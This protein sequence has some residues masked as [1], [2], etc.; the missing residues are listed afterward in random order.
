M[1]TLSEP[2]IREHHFYVATAKSV[3]AHDKYGIVL[4]R[5]P[6]SLADAARYGL[7]PLLLYGIT[8]AGTPIRWSTYSLAS[9]PRSF[10]S[11]LQEA[12]QLA[13]GLRGR[14]DVLKVNRHIMA[15]STSL[16]QPH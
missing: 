15:A 14:P 6:M 4:V 2:M 5:D 11:V 12:W 7:K 9:E 8:A 1:P 16:S 10:C 13:P 3:F